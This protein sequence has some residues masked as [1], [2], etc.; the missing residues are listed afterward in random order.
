MLTL[1]STNKRP[2][3]PEEV[4]FGA[5]L[6]RA[7][8]ARKMTHGQL[9]APELEGGAGLNR[10]SVSKYIDGSRPIPRPGEVLAIARV[11]DVHFAWL[12]IGEGPSGLPDD[13]TGEGG[14]PVL[15]V[16]KRAKS[17]SFRVPDDI[18][19]LGRRRFPPADDPIA[20]R[21]RALFGIE[22]KLEPRTVNYLLDLEGSEAEARTED[23]WVDLAEQTQARFRAYDR[24]QWEADAEELG[25]SWAGA[26]GRSLGVP[27]A[28]LVGA[29]RVRDAD[30]SAAWGATKR[31]ARTRQASPPEE[32][33]WLAVARRLALTP[34][35][36]ARGG[37]CS[38]AT[39][40]QALAYDRSHASIAPPRGPPPVPHA[41]KGPPCRLPGAGRRP[42]GGRL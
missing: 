37:P 23:E 35:P 26:G 33:S 13:P 22:H 12:S 1:V 6:E 27:A 7:L 4:G 29:G 14:A 34:A 38:D 24:R 30:A 42:L 10:G 41:P 15:R 17:D 21:R 40:R 9:E 11:L 2:L 25:K 36:R 31:S 18:K 3:R 28:E 32:S 16:P 19:A 20:N 8:K 5:R 39:H